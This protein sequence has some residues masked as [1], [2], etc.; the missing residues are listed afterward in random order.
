MSLLRLVV[1]PGGSLLKGFYTLDPFKPELILM[2]PDVTTV[3]LESLENYEQTKIGESNPENSAWIEY[4]NKCQAVG[5]LARKRFNSDLQLQKRKFELALPKV[6]AMVGAIADKH[7]LE[8][9]TAIHLGIL[10]PWGEYQDRVLFQELVTTALSNYKFKGREKIFSLELFLCLPEGG[11]IFSR[12]I[13]PGSN[14]KEKSFAVVML[15]YRDASILLID[16]GEM[17]KG[18]T[19]PLGFSKMVESVKR[20]TSGLNLEELTSAICKSGKNA[21]H[22]AL[23]E[24]ALNVDPVYRE[25]ETSRIRNAVVTCKEEYWMMLSNWLKLQVPRDVDEVIISGGTAHYFQSQ[26]NNLFS[27]SHVNWCEILEKQLMNSFPQAVSKS[28]NHRLTDVYGLFFFL[29]AKGIRQSKEVVGAGA[30]PIQNSK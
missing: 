22:K 27:F 30:I 15:G 24:L 23:G 14:L 29:C 10:L 4:Q 25:Y 20:Q 11:G 2:E 21:S 12:G 18:K 1:D 13:A 17:S 7:E 9:G 26:L 8:N 28:L 19:D 16:R 6:L 3:P 5:F